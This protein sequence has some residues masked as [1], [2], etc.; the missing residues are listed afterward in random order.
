V[1]AQAAD[2]P[3]IKKIATVRVSIDFMGKSL[4]PPP[5]LVED[6]AAYLTHQRRRSPRTVAA[7]G[8]ILRR[9]F[10]FSDVLLPEADSLRAF[11]REAAQGL[12]PSSQAQWAS[13]L[14]TFLAWGAR[15]GHWSPGLEKHLSRP[16]VPKRL[17][18]VVEEEDLPLLL[19]TI[20]KR[21]PLERLLF[22]LLY[23]SGLRISEALNLRRKGINLRSASAEILGKGQR[24]RKVPLTGRACKVL[25]ALPSGEEIWPPGTNVRGLRRWVETW[26]KLSLLSE[27]TGRLHPHKLRH[28]LASHLLRRGAKLPQIQKLLGHR[29]LGTTERYTHLNPEDLINAYDKAF[30]KLKR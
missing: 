9:Y 29:R 12:S 24:L 6:F 1:P 18:K 15:A 26:G 10:E 21:P 28:S 14:K 4:T 30:P 5:G 13:A 8:D 16:K 17:I 11:L 23:G 25:A 22:E 7:Y 19:A 27:E 2:I 20:D 3:V